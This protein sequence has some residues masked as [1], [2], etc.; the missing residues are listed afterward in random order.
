MV[1]TS[2]RPFRVGTTR[3]VIFWGGMEVYEDFVAWTHDQEMAF[4][5]YGATQEVWTRFGEHY[6]VKDNGDGSYMLAVSV[7]GTSRGAERRSLMKSRWMGAFSDG[8][9]Q[10]SGDHLCGS[11]GVSPW[12]AVSAA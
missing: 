3:T 5:F 1:W 4:V 10:R 6:R 8:V 7:P 9:R 12:F 2:P 11:S